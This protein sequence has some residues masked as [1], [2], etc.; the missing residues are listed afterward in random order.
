MQ[1]L[2]E[3]LKVLGAVLPIE[4]FVFFG[5]FLDEIFPPIPSPLVMMVAVASLTSQHAGWFVYFA[6]AA[7]AAVGK[8]VASLLL[9][10]VGN[11]GETIVVSKYGKWL[12]VSHEQIAQMSAHIN[13]SWKDD[14]LLFVSRMLPILPT[15]IVSIVCGIFKTNYKHF[16]WLTLVGMFIRNLVMMVLVIYGA[17]E[18]QQLTDLL[19]SDGLI[20]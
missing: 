1:F 20:K 17:Q 19:R 13:R 5:S 4:W 16:F 2:I 10:W 12:R 14:V 7:V 11:K 6:I 8:T 9:Y 3:W 18:L 15:T